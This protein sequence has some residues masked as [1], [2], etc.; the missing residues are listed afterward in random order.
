M[1]QSGMVAQGLY[2]L[3]KD[4]GI[5]HARQHRFL[6]TGTEVEWLQQVRPG[7]SVTIQGLLLAWRRNRIRTNVKMLGEGDTL[8]AEAKIAG[9]GVLWSPDSSRIP[10]ANG[11]TV[12][13][14][15]AESQ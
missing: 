7:Q 4:K 1:C 5:E 8:V 9:L 12:E 3:T 2:L 15:Q 11:T 13:Y 6:V 14:E 10:S